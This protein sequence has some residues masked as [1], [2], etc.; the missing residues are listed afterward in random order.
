VRKLI[1]VFVFEGDLLDVGVTRGQQ[2]LDHFGAA[3]LASPEQGRTT[4]GSLTDNILS[5]IS[6]DFF[7]LST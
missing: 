6:T 5:I 3:V 7:D 1:N 2:V 4:V